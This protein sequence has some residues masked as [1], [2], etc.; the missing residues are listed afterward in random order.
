MLHAL[1]LT[2]GF[3]RPEVATEFVIE[4]RPTSSGRRSAERLAGLAN[5]EGVPGDDPRVCITLNYP[6]SYRPV[7]RPQDVVL[8]K[9][10][11]M[12]VRPLGLTGPVPAMK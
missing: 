1:A 7:V 3:P 5:A 9:G 6:S 10:D 12:V 4:R 11:V 8:N 2:G